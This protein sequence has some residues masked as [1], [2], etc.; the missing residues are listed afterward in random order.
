[1]LG[2]ELATVRSLMSGSAVANRISGKVSPTTVIVTNHH[3]V[4]QLHLRV[5][6]W[7]E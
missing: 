6:Q 2:W 5:S 4:A 7:S 1:M 3:M